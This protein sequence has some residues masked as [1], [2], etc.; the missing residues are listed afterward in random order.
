MNDIPESTMTR[1]PLR[2]SGRAASHLC[3][4]SSFCLATTR[5]VTSVG[6]AASLHNAT[7]VGNQAS[8]HFGCRTLTHN[9]TPIHQ[10]I[11]TVPGSVDTEG[12][13]SGEVD[14]VACWVALWA[15]GALDCNN[16][17]ILRDGFAGASCWVPCSVRYC[18][19]VRYCCDGV[20]HVD[21][22]QPHKQP[23][24]WKGS[25]T[26]AVS[27]SMLHRAGQLALF[28]CPCDQAAC[29]FILLLLSG[30]I[31]K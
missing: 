12:R 7:V 26:T 13:L 23:W 22:K 1:A 27:C 29:L 21:D 17:K 18:A 6:S 16:S 10:Y 14:G 11:T 20:N 9:T 25:M 2:V 8:Y 19:V 28:S 30:M 31:I 4:S 24:Q 5:S 15:L 3:S